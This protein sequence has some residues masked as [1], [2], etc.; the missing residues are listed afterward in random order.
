MNFLSKSED[1]KLTYNSSETY[2][3]CWLQWQTNWDQST[4]KSR[5]LGEKM[6]FNE[7]G[8]RARQWERI[9]SNSQPLK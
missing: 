4:I 6:G 5:F 9:I 7:G 8:D 1:L 2:P 3:P